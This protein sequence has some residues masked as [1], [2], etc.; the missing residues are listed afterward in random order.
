MKKSVIIVIPVILSIIGVMSYS[1][2]S[3]NTT[4]TG[5][6]NVIS[7]TTSTCQTVNGV[8]PD[9]KCTPGAAD[10]SVTQD[11]ID[12][13]ICVSG[14]TKTVRPPVSVTDPIKQEH[15]QAYGF[16]DSPKNY[17]LDH[18][19]PLEIGGAPADVRNLWPESRY[20]DL[21]SYDKDKFENYLHKQVCAGAL[22]LKTAQNEI[23][24]NW[25]KYW[26]D[27]GKP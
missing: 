21:N 20:T 4:Q 9:P 16:T 15:M 27:A 17:E 1:Q 13:T 7:I 2:T 19:I 11:N 18:L 10:P 5:S 6:N 8:L 3:H 26:E 12:S 24:S 22:S 23:A 25:L 14:Y